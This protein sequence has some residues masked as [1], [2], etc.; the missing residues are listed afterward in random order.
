MLTKEKPKDIAIKIKSYSHQ[1]FYK[2]KF[3]D[4]EKIAQRIKNKQ[5][6]STDKN[7]FIIIKEIKILSALISQYRTKK[8][9]LICVIKFH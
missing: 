2:D 5:D 6:I 3:I 8:N 1:E 7:F 4:E 9:L